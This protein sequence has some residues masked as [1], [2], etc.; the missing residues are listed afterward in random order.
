MQELVIDR[1]ETKKPRKEGGNPFYVV[2]GKNGEEMTS[3]DSAVME[4]GSGTVLNVEPKI[5][6]KHINIMKFEVVKKTDASTHS[7]VVDRP[8]SY[9]N[10]D[11]PEKQK[12]I[13]NQS[14]SDRITELL[15]SGKLVELPSYEKHIKNLD[16]WLLRLGN[17]NNVP[18]PPAVTSSSASTPVTKSSPGIPASKSR[19]ATAGEFMAAVS[20]NWGKYSDDVVVTLGIKSAGEVKDFDASWLELELKWGKGKGI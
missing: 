20:K 16:A 12:S 6:G 9:S 2:F 3:F 11:S 15:I 10:G 8:S 1:V 17:C 14:R 4:F 18:E 7:Q 5:S 19:F 13:E